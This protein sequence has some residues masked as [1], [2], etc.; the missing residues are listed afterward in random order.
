[1]YRCISPDISCLICTIISFPEGETNYQLS[2]GSAVFLSLSIVLSFLVF[3]VFLQMS[4]LPHADNV[5]T[6]FSLFVYRS[7]LTFLIHSFSKLLFQLKRRRKLLFLFPQLL[8]F[9]IFSQLS[10]VFLNLFSFPQSVCSKNTF[11]TGVFS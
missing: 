11:C 3:L 8:R 5:E 4:A 9:S 1:M 2:Q 6:Y 10:Q 7:S